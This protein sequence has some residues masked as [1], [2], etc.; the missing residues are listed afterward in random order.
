MTY[1]EYQLHGDDI[2]GNFLFDYKLS[3]VEAYSKEET[4]NNLSYSH[5]RYPLPWS[6]YNNVRWLAI[7]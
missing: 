6:N 2:F 3:K 5:E 1:P 4:A 7:T